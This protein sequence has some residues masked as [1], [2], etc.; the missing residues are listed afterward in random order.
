MA[1]IALVTGATGGIGGEFVHEICS[2]PAYT[3]IDEIWAIGRNAEKLAS[4]RSASTKVVSV[5]ADLS[6]DG[7]DVLGRKLRESAPDIRL[8]V[9]NA[10]TA[11]MGLF[12]KMGKEQVECMCRTNCD[13]IAA[14]I[15]LS[16]PYMREGAA[17][18]NVSSAASFQPNPYLTLY[19]ASKVFVRQL[20]RA[21]AV[22]L[23]GRG[24]HV[25]CVCPGWVDT[26]MLPREKDGRKIHYPGMTSASKVA[27]KALSDSRKGK[28]MSVPSLFAK[29]CHIYGKIMPA[30]LVM[31]Q[32]TRMTARYV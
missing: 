16:L 8:L 5:E 6:T 14:L 10:G 4:L 11:Y 3:E 32:W 21:L 13:A 19:S 27:R 20:S 17:I 22:E 23:K 25:T 24:I 7:I 30:G 2:N 15:A 12:E 9:N 31:R 1:K 18:V 28:T 29:F 26:G